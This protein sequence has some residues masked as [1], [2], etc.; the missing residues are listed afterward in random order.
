MDDVTQQA[1]PIGQKLKMCDWCGAMRC[2]GNLV[3]RFDGLTVC[4]EKE[5]NCNLKGPKGPSQYPHA[6]DNKGR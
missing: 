5:R 1:C 6:T 2:T 3:K 4:R